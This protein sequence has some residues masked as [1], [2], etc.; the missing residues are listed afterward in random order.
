MHS[1]N[2]T[3]AS[4]PS[5][6]RVNVTV[7]S[8]SWALRSPAFNALSV[9]GEMPRFFILSCFCATFLCWDACCEVTGGMPT[10]GETSYNQRH[11]KTG[12]DN[13]ARVYL[14][15]HTPRTPHL[16]QL[17][18]ARTVTPTHKHTR[19]SISFSHARTS[20]RISNLCVV[21][22]LQWRLLPSVQRMRRC[23]I[24]KKQLNN[25]F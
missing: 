1:S 10:L 23:S 7:T 3:T 5:H 14:P 6:N 19:L 12:D 2:N 11:N 17:L 13:I 22:T 21:S 9:A 8:N 25:A 16:V 4:I 20:I 15:A 18:L 24:V